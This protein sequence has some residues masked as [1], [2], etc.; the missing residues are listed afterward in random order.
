MGKILGFTTRIINPDRL[1][2]QVTGKESLFDNS[3]FDERTRLIIAKSKVSVG[4]LI[5]KGFSTADEIFIPV[6]SAKDEFLIGFAQKLINF[7]GSQISFLDVNNYINKT[8]ELKEQI[9]AMEQIAPNHVALMTESGITPDFLK[10]QHLMLISVESW[11]YLLEKK[12]TWLTDIP[13]TLI[14]ANKE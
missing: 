6:V 12:S 5:D 10:Q 8:S 1:I 7:S 4:V 2:Q 9:R 14:I 13:S 11:K 3:P